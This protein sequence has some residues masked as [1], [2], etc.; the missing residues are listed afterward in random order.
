MYK[1]RM[2]GE[3]PLLETKSESEAKV[4]KQKRYAQILEILSSNTE[5]MSAKEIAVEMYKKGYIP[6]AERNYSAPRITELLDMGKVDCV[7]KK[8][9]KYTGHSVGVF[10]ERENKEN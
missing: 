2:P 8:I 3:N 10:I 6:I 9:C 4:P 7:G 1:K 5:P